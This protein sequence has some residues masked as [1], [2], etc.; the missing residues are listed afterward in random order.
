[1]RKVIMF[2]LIS[3]DGFFEGA[4]KWDLSWH[5]VDEEFNQFALAQLDQAD[6]LIFGRVTYQGMA[7]YWT[8]DEAMANDPYIA[9]KMNSIRKYVFS[10][11]LDKAD[12]NNTRLINGEAASEL[13][14]LKQQSGKDLLLFG[15]ASLAETFIKNDQIDEYR[16]LVIPVVLGKGGALFKVDSG[17]LNLKLLNTRTFNNGN[18]LLYYQPDGR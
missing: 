3:L 8:T 4:S 9:S 18:L 15:S 2:N 10:K 6:G 12:W 14:K 5:L 1:M 11:T 16:L 13:P 17:M 7:A